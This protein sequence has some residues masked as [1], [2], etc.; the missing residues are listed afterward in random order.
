M[1]SNVLLLQNYIILLAKF[2][3]ILP[4]FSFLHYCL[5]F[6]LDRCKMSLVDLVGNR[7][8]LIEQNK[9]LDI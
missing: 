4:R 2:Q 7:I 6:R 9:V 8:V 3:Y 1:N 5:I